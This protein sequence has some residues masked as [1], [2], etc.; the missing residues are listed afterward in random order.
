MRRN[1]LTALRAAQAGFKVFPTKG[2]GEDYKAPIY[3]FKWGRWATTNPSDIKKWVK[4][5]NYFM[6]CISLKNSRYFVVDTDVKNNLDG[7]TPFIDLLQQHNTDINTIAQTYTPSGGRHFYFKLPPSM[8]KISN[9]KGTLPKGI[10]I[11]GNNSCV[12]ARST[13]TQEGKKYYIGNIGNIKITDTIIAPKWLLDMLK[14]PKTFIVNLSVYNQNINSNIKNNEYSIRKINQYKNN[15]LKYIEREL[16]N[17]HQG[18]RNNTLFK[19]AVFMGS[20]VS[21]DIITFSEG[22]AILERISNSIGLRTFEIRRTI[23]SGLKKGMLKP[24]NLNK[25]LLEAKIK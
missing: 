3:G 23:N 15:S 19:T 24:I 5:Y 6:P 20:M 12:M 11:R 18:N 17:A 2:Y 8:D 1:L 25:I 16:L 7:L 13:T 4:E 22:W 9:Y 10:D 21:A 14:E